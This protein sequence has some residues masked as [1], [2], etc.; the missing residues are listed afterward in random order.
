MNTS[1]KIEVLD[2]TLRDGGYINSWNFSENIILS[3]IKKLASSNIDYIECGLLDFEKPCDEN[4]TLFNSIEILHKLLAKNNIKTNCTLMLNYKD[5]DLSNFSQNETNIEIRLAFKPNEMEC[6]TS[7]AQKLMDKG[8]KLSLNAMHSSLYSKNDLIKL[9]S[10]TNE[11]NPH[12]LTFVDTMGIMSELDT[13][14]IFTLADSFLKDEISLGFHSHNNMN[15]SFKNTV[16]L[17]N[18]TLNRR[19]IIDACL[20]GM[21]RGAGILSTEDICLYLNEKCKD[22]YNIDFLNG[23]SEKYIKPIKARTDW[24]FS[25]PYYLSAKY[26]CHPNYAKYLIDRNISD[27]ENILAKIPQNAKIYYDKEVIHDILACE[28]NNFFNE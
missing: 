9:L 1:N 18:L 14:N 23:I 4:I 2:C 11:I 25:K 27:I 12:C 3:I 16:E 6:A 5:Y 20:M 7:F 26:K 8:Y 28:N 17:I 22:K 21:G 19:I 10:Y 24:G 15:L 13:K